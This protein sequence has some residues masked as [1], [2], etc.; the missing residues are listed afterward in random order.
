MG[1][2]RGESGGRNAEPVIIRSRE[3]QERAC[4]AEDSHRDKTEQS[5]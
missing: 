5:M 3:E 4:E 1:T 2:R